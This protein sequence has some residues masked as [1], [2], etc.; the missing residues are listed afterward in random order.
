MNDP[1]EEAIPGW[2]GVDRRKGDRRAA[3]PS[4]DTKAVERRE[5]SDRRRAQYCHRCG[6]IFKPKTTAGTVCP[7]CRMNALRMGQGTGRWG[8]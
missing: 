6:G 1:T 4:G 3:R 8:F 5:K 7:S 2:D